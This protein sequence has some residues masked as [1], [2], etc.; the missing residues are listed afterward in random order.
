MGYTNYWQG[1]VPALT[2]DLRSKIAGVLHEHWD[3]LGGWDGEGI[4]EF[5]DSRLSF[6]GKGE[7]AHETF[8]ITFG[9]PVVFD[10]CKTRRKA[11]DMAVREVLT[12]LAEVETTFTWSCDD[13]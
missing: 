2:D 6:N 3:V 12:L 13:D 4:P 8:R 5:N 1:E 7:N 10:F 11:Y 9:R